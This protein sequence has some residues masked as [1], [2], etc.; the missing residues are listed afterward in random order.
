M[1]TDT[2][3][4]WAQVASAVF[5]A[6]IAI[7]AIW[8]D[9]IRR[10]LLP[11]NL[12]LRKHNFEGDLNIQRDGKKVIYYHLKVINTKRYMA[13]KVRV[14]CEALS[15]MTADRETFQI[16]PFVVPIQMNWAHINFQELLP[17]VGPERIVDIGFLVEGA[18][19]FIIS[20]ITTPGN[21]KGQI[22]KGETL[23]FRLV[24]T[25][26]NQIKS[27]PLFLQ[28]AWAGEF[29]FDSKEMSKHLVISIVD[30]LGSDPQST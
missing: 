29:V 19:H 12:E 16:E 5:T 17:N 27:K 4:V 30:S 10:K 21:F 3:A 6:V 14:M 25:A 23:R 24:A 15:R 9:A 28:I 7:V 26:D 11:P 22:G 1:N 20:L 2:I 18:D 13:H 8:G